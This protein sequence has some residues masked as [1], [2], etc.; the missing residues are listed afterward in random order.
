MAS[1]TGTRNNVIA[2][3]FVIAS[4][5]LAVVISVIVSGAQKR[6]LPTHTYYIRFPVDQGTPGIK[7][8]SIVNLGGLEVGRVTGVDFDEPAH[9]GFIKVRIAIR[10]NITLY[11]DAWAFLERPLLGTTSTLNLASTGTG[12]LPPGKVMQ[13]N[14][15]VLEPFE[16][17]DGRIAPPSFLAQ[18]GYGPEQIKQFQT[19]IAQASEV[20]DRVNRMSVRLE[21]DIDPTLS[22]LRQI[23]DSVQ[24]ASGEFT[25]RAPDWAKSVDQILA[26]ADDAGTRLNAAL[27]HA[28][29]AV[30]SIRDTI[31][32]NRP[33]VDNTIANIREAAE[34]VNHESV[35]LVNQTLEKVGKG[36]EE[37]S[38]A[39]GRFN[40][41]VT[42]ELP[43][44]ERMLANLR[45]ASDQAKLTMVEVRR[46]PWRIF[47]RPQTKELESELFYDAARS[48]AEAVSNLR[49]ASEALQAT[50]Q[51]GSSL[52][53]VQRET[54]ADL[55]A[56]LDLAFGTYKDAER[57]LM[58]LLNEKAP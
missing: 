41:L 1:R 17:L 58:K 4:A 42:Q 48:Y 25:Q 27:D 20:V 11:E 36:S 38:A 16:E 9:P 21:S 47:Y 39:A 10:S 7:K 30:R 6:L 33:A 2:G 56:R 23:V 3:L 43:N 18:A 8:G 19:M 51:A 45:M 26:K 14:S 12:Q 40:A 54:A 57:K 52:P 37:F 55:Q 35:A 13:G 50:A 44:I 46:N 5:V 53:Q 29:A 34:T 28:D 22:K 31:E 15:P 49:A 32:T 24:S